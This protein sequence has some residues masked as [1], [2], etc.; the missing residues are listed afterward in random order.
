[1]MKFR[2]KPEGIQENIKCLCRAIDITEACPHPSS[3][4]EID[5]G[6]IKKLKDT[7]QPPIP[8]KRT[9]VISFL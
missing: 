7:H 6:G 4:C 1:M 2:G 3:L 8:E 5:L 9:I